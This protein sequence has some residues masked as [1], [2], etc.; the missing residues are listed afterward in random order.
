MQG[1]TFCLVTGDVSLTLAPEMRGDTLR[2]V[3]ADGCVWVEFAVVERERYVTLTIREWQGVADQPDA[4]LQVA[5]P[6]G[7]R[8]HLTELDYM[9]SYREQGGARRLSWLSPSKHFGGNP[10][11]SFAVFAADTD[12]EH[13]ETLL[14]I[15]VDE[16]QPHPNTGDPW[17]LAY[18]RQWLADWQ[19][20]FGKRSQMVV[21]GESLQELYDLVPYAEKPVA[22]ENPCIKVNDSS[23]Q[24]TGRIATGNYLV[25][26]DGDAVDVYDPNWHHI[27]QLA[28]SHNDL[29]AHPGT[30]GVVIE[31][32]A[33][34][35]HP[36]L[37]CQFL[38]KDAT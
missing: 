31:T 33:R 38:V 21:N 11:G 10:A 25:Y 19:S 2:V 1:A 8:L 26:N 36:W 24:V 14:R 15:W 30:N 22:L 16:N 9:G 35:T 5:I 32:S 13:D 6:Q 23:L 34:D 3:A 20:T 28:V 4:S 7:S 37:E 17:T 18:A 29:H 27:E 12:E